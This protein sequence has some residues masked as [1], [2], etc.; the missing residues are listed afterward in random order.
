MSSD[1]YYDWVRYAK[2]AG[3]VSPHR[4][5]ERTMQIEFGKLRHLLAVIHTP[6][7]RPVPR[8]EDF[9]PRPDYQDDSTGDAQ[10][11]EELF[12]RIGARSGKSGVRWRRKKGS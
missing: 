2:K 12:G 10:Q 9:M 1:E 8:I 5:L 6:K 7:G 11:I 3:G 4:R